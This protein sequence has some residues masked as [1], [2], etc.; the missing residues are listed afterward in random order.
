MVLDPQ[1]RTLLDQFTR[2]GIK[3]LAELSVQQAREQMLV[4]SCFLGP[5]APV[6]AVEDLE[7]PGPAGA[8]AVRLYRPHA[9]SGLPALVYLHGGGW[10]MGSIATHDALCRNLCARANVAVASVEYRLAPEHKFPA[11]LEDSYAATNYLATHAESLGLHPERLAVGGDSAGG[12]LAAALTLLARQRGGPAIRFQLLIYPV[13]DFDFDTPSYRENANGFHLTRDEMIWCW[14][15]YLARELDG[16][17]PLASPL[18]TEDLSGLPAAMVVTAQYDPLRDEGEAYAE[19]L[20]QAGVP[21][22]LKRYAGMIHG[23]IRRPSQLDQAQFALDD[24]AQTLRTSLLDS[25][26]SQRTASS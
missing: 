11:A 21:V 8:V 4:G 9:D 1:A 26:C 16:Y 6:H 5:G 19:R 7:I 24:V 14:R 15:Q 25:G 3:P 12:N 22:T 23:F 20:V 18:R 10:M 13:L 2:S 17:T